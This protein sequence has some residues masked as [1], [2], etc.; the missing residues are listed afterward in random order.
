MIE[1]QVTNISN[2][3]MGQ[4]TTSVDNLNKNM[5]LL[6]QKIGN[7]STALNRRYDTTNAS[8]Q[9]LNETYGTDVNAKT[10]LGGKITTFT[11]EM[12]NIFNNIKDYVKK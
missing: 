10:V 2:T 3:T 9:E 11:G 7:T 8:I 5:N 1:S 4:M 6:S 12:L